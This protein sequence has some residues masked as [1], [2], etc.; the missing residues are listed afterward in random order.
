MAAFTLPTT[1]AAFPRDLGNYAGAVRALVVVVLGA[2][3]WST[4][5]GAQGAELSVG[6]VAGGV[7]ARSVTYDGKVAWLGQLSLHTGARR[8]WLF[9]FGYAHLHDSGLECCADTPGIRY[10]QQAVLVSWGYEVLR[11]MGRTTSV[12]IDVQHTP[13][14]SRDTRR[15]SIPGFTPAPFGWEPSVATGSVGL[16]LRWRATPSFHPHL[17]VRTFIESS[18]LILGGRPT[19]RPAIQLGIGRR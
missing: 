16:T 1:R 9:G 6:P 7:P 14:V 18:G 19:I 8:G 2:S 15:G 10:G 3:V 4:T 11:S 13:S 5:L 12:G 17:A